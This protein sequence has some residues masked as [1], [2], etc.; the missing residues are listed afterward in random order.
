MDNDKLYL[1]LGSSGA[2][3]MSLLD[4]VQG[5]HVFSITWSIIALAYLV[6]IF[7]ENKKR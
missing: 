2:T 4:Y 5:K 1:V 3:C 6:L 7:I